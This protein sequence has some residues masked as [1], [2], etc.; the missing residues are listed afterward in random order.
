MPCR[1]SR[2]RTPRAGGDEGKAGRGQKLSPIDG[3]LRVD[4][5]VQGRPKGVPCGRCAEREHYRTRSCSVGGSNSVAARFTMEAWSCGCPDG[6]ALAGPCARELD[7]DHKHP[8]RQRVFVFTTQFPRGAAA[9]GSSGHRCPGGALRVS[10][11]LGAAGAL[12]AL[13]GPCARELH[14]ERKHPG[15]QGVLVFTI[16]FPRGAATG[17]SSGHRGPGTAS[18]SPWCRELRVPCGL[19][20][21]PVRV[22][23]AS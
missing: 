7:R 4:A 3:G 20:R 2:R 14:R 11:V 22:K 19:W 8:G 6:P 21:G 16:E 15:R 23:V 5:R 12:R 1:Q 9:G 18:V 13:A 17:G 10:M